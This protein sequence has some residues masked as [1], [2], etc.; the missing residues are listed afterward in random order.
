MFYRNITCILRMQGVWQT[1]KRQVELLWWRR[2][3]ERKLWK[4]ERSH[5]DWGN[6]RMSRYDRITARSHSNNTFGELFPPFTTTGNQNTK[7]DL[8]RKSHT[9]CEQIQM[10]WVFLRLSK[11]SPI[12]TV[13]LHQQCRKRVPLVVWREPRSGIAALSAARGNFCAKINPTKLIGGKLAKAYAQVKPHAWHTH[14]KKN[15]IC[16]LHI[17]CTFTTDIHSFN[18][19]F[20]RRRVT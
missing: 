3:L 10:C 13:A 11:C 14:L 1:G 20:Q 12:F 15:I 19:H 9:L 18:F 16:C 6:W 7:L 8:L 5:M 2:N 17:C 4:L